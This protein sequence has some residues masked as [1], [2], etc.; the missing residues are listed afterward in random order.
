MTETYGTRHVFA[1]IHQR[2]LSGEIRL[3]WIFT[4]R[5][6]LQLY[7][8]P[9]LAVGKYDE[10][11]ELAQPKSFDYNIYGQGKSTIDYENEYY[12]VQEG[13]QQEACCDSIT[14]CVDYMGNCIDSDS[15]DYEGHSL[16]CSSFYI[17]NTTSLK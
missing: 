2:V 14:D 17:N 7:L 13:N 4:P 12:I 16:Y 8:Q 1:R 3:N 6:S 5:L 15:P 11:R 9:F 10:F